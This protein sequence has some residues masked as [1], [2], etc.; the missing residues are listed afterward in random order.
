MD[1][2]TWLSRE[3]PEYS[4]V[5]T[6]PLDAVPRTEGCSEFKPPNVRNTETRNIQLHREAA[7]S[8]ALRLAI[9]VITDRI[10]NSGDPG[11]NSV[12]QCLI[13]RECQL[14]MKKMGNYASEGERQL[15]SEIYG[16]FLKPSKSCLDKASPSGK[17]FPII[18]RLPAASSNVPSTREQQA[19]S[20]CLGPG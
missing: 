5:V 17:I 11:R 14:R 16:L 8:R 15:A 9:A 3:Y 10:A 19:V 20:G 7:Q 18:R 2:M 13:S 1:Y 4:H 12:A 6:S